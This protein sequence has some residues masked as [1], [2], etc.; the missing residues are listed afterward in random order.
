M[1]LYKKVVSEWMEIKIPDPIPRDISF[2]EKL[3]DEFII[4]VIGPRRAGKTYFMYQTMKKLI[5]SGVSRERIFYINLEDERLSPLNSKVMD[6]ILDAFH[7]L[8]GPHDEYYLFL[9]EIQ[10]MSGWQS[11]LKRIK[12]LEGAKIMVSGSSSRLLSKELATELRGQVYP[13]EVFTISFKEFVR[14]RGYD[15]EKLTKIPYGKIG[16]TGR[17][18]FSEYM[19]TSSYPALIFGNFDDFSTREILQGYYDAMVLRDVMERYS[20]RD[21]SLLRSL[22]K[23]LL[24][25]VAS[26]FTYTKLH[27]NLRSIGFSPSKSTVVEYVSYLQDAYL[28]FTLS[29][30]NTSEKKRQISPKKVYVIDNGFI[31]ALTFTGSEEIGKKLE[32]L[33][34]LELL[35]K[36]KSIFYYKD[37]SEC[38]FVVV[39]RGRPV[40]AIQVTE[41][42]ENSMDREIRGLK[43]AMEDT[44][45]KKGTIITINER[46][47]IG[48]VGVIP[49]WEWFL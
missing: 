28:F 41:S 3:M 36:K 45:A 14:F 21:I 34:F 5:M 4:A 22:S 38:D 37:V 15:P 13:I 40:E 16:I 33:V 2:N 8:Y 31:D 19:K 32:N 1:E 48:N 30:F 11:W 18:L 29:R 10:N 9:D 26:E 20:L 39:E 47:S 43:K 12:T 46:K 25:S 49:A 44:G 17:K 24:N 6:Y 42:L 35:R 23:L 27:K 7:E